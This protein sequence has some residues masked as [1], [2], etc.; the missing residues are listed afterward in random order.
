M[1]S[2]MYKLL[3]LALTAVMLCSACVSVYAAEV[4]VLK[5]YQSKSYVGISGNAG[6]ENAGYEASVILVKKGETPSKESIGYIGQSRIDTN[7]NYNF[8]FSFEGLEYENNVVSNYDI[9]LNV[10]GTNMEKTITEAKVLSDMITFESFD[11]SAFG[12]AVTEID[13]IYGLKDIDYLLIIAYYDADDTLLKVQPI[14]RYTGDEGVYSYNSDIPENAAYARGF[15]W[16]DTV[17]MFPLTTPQTF[18]FESYTGERKAQFLT[19]APGR[20]ETE[21]NFAWYDIGGVEK[22]RLQYAVKN[23]GTVADFES[24]DA[25]TVVGTCGPTDVGETYNGINNGP[26]KETQVFRHSWDFTWAKATATGLKPG[27]TYVYRVGDATGWCDGIYE[28]KTDSAPKDGFNFILF[29]DEHAEPADEYAQPT[30]T[31]TREKAIEICPDA[32]FIFAL[33]DNV[34]VP[35]RETSYKEYFEREKMESIPLATVPGGTHDMMITEFKASLFDYHFNMPNQCDV[36]DDESYSGYIENVGGNY[37]YLYGDVLVIATTYNAYEEADVQKAYIE[38]AVREASSQNP[39]IK[40][41]IWCTHLPV[42]EEDADKDLTNY[43]NK[44]YFWEGNDD[45]VKDNGIDVVFTG[46]THMSYRSYQMYSGERVYGTEETNNVTNPKGTVYISHNTTGRQAYECNHDDAFVAFR[47]AETWGS[48]RPGF[49]DRTVFYTHFST[50]NIKKD[51]NGND[52]FEYKLY[53]N[54]F[55]KAT[56]TLV[57]S[58]VIDIYTITKT[59]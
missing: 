14:K 17:K 9:V 35:W 39:N 47:D 26:G 29:S 59:N 38:K 33:G 27:K 45:F 4:P 50:V 55:D 31:Q 11:F 23:T 57:D 21:R 10:N 2:L 12:K 40:W 6:S 42:Y 24:P 22:V 16:E 18:D 28:F 19:I 5:A 34:D 53:K 3:A 51:S 44:M 52:V 37:W 1:K 46:H 8:E 49:T 25:K 7:G 41:K 36:N 56:K 54:E 43:R 30:I 13:S 58:E 20:N 15:V 32:S 48:S